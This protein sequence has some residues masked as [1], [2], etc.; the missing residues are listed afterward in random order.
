MQSL[1]SL[2]KAETGALMMVFPRALINKDDEDAMSFYIVG[3]KHYLLCAANTWSTEDP[4]GSCGSLPYKQV[5]QSWFGWARLVE[6]V[7]SLGQ[8]SLA[9]PNFLGP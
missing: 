4:C 3:S 7:A 5:C 1:Q 9:A 2:G 8:Q 6:V